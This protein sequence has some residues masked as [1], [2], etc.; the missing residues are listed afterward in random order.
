MNYTWNPVYNYVMEVKSRFIEATGDSSIENVLNAGEYES[1]F[2]RWLAIVNDKELSDIATPLCIKQ[3]IRRKN[4]LQIRYKKYDELFSM[5]DFNYNEF[6]KIRDGFYKESRTL[7]IDIINDDIVISGFKKFCNI[8]E[9]DDDTLVNLVKR[10][11]DNDGQYEVS[12]K[13]DG[14]L[15]CA[16]YPSSASEPMFCTSSCIDASISWRLA[17]AIEMF[18]KNKG[19]LEMLYNNPGMTFIFEYISMK[20][21]HIVVYSKEQEGIYLI[22]IRNNFTGFEY[23]YKVV[24]TMAHTY[25]VLTTNVF[26]KSIDDVMADTK[27]YKHNELEGY[28]VKVGQYRCKIKTEDYVLMHKLSASKFSQNVTIQMFADGKFD[29]YYASVPMDMRGRVDWVV[30]IINE[31][32]SLTTKCVEEYTNKCLESNKNGTRKDLM[33]WCNANVP[34]FIRGNVINKILGRKIRLMFNGGGG[35]VKLDEM[36]NMIDKIKKL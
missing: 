22:G 14:S 6:W 9:N 12:E 24:C 7:V 35:Y 8:G 34:S 17:D 16:S 31:Y 23:S 29:D 25:G 28:V 10:I 5:V 13:K 3:G 36:K 15:F 2:H 27:K 30:E 19:Y 21:P 4:H 26:N 11:N 20:D 33:L 32:I 1:C 18:Y